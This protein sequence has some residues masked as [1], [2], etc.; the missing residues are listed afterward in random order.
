MLAMHRAHTVLVYAQSIMA[1]QVALEHF[2]WSLMLL[3]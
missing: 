3:G 1:V 2:A